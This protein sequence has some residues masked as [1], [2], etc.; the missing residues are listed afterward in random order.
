MIRRP[1]RSTLFPY[2]T[3]FRSPGSGPRGLFHGQRANVGQ[4]PARGGRAHAPLAAPRS[5]AAR[6]QCGRPL[7]L[8]GREGSSDRGR[9]ERLAAGAAQAARRRRVGGRLPAGVGP[10]S[11]Q[12]SG[13]RLGL[14]GAERGRD[15][16]RRAGGAGGGAA[17]SL[18]RLTAPVLP[19]TLAASR[20]NCS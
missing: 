7:Q 10:V 15:G 2:T 5:R 14:G 11:L 6:G 17:R 19:P 4:A 20:W 13:R 18:V 9:L 3:L 16:A 1:P 12:S 8:R